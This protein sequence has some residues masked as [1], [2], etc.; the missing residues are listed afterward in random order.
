MSFGNVPNSDNMGAWNPNYGFDGFLDEV[1][2]T[3][4]VARYTENFTVSARAF[5]DQGPAGN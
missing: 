1:R 3:L 2:I 4:G 5:P